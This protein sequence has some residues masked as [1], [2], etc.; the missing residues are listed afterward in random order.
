MLISKNADGFFARKCSP[1]ERAKLL[2]FFFAAWIIAAGRLYAA[3][4]ESGF[5]L[6]PSPS[7]SPN[8]RAAAYQ[9]ARSLVI[10]AAAKYEKTPYRY[11]GT[12]RSGLDC[13]GLVYV[14]FREA[15]GV[16]VPRT[17][18]ALYEWV[19]KIPLENALPGDL[20]F[21][22]TGGGP[23]SHVGIFTGDRRFIHAAS[24]GRSTG[25]IYSTLD[26][27]YWSRTFA[28]VG[29]VFP[30]GGGTAAKNAP[31]A[32]PNNP[33]NSGNPGNIQPPVKKER[34]KIGIL[35]GAG[36]APS[37]NISFH[38]GNVVRGIAGQLMVGT[39]VKPFGK[40]MILGLEVRPEWDEM[41]GVFRIPLTVSWGLDEKWRIFAG[42]AISF[43]SAALKLSDGKTRE[44]PKGNNA[45]FGAAG[46]T[47]APF[48][49]SIAGTNLAP[50]A[51][52]AWQSYL[53]NG[54]NF[55]FADIT[56]GLRFSTGLRL[57][58]QM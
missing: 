31:P 26:E 22:V 49:F 35:M 44:Y 16:T 24:E 21:F 58:W 18:T 33:G 25:V 52:L 28:G 34:E 19:E 57:T 30:E 39:E 41:L 7:A 51:E 37:W 3:P 10:A 53:K 5:A 8:E 32:V 15:L 54:G 50:Y 48:A 1:Y 2:L 38:D 47:A 29:R 6:A 9:E 56:A 36:I 20:L 11:A 14:S 17:T 12:D 40:P 45:W 27:S 43:G 4:L 13:S 55:K 23:I 42:P 46:I